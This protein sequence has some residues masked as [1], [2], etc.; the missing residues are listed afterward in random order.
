MPTVKG[1]S[2]RLFLQAAN[3]YSDSIIEKLSAKNNELSFYVSEKLDGTRAFWDGGMTRG[4][5]T[6]DVP[7]ANT[8]DPN[9][10]K[11]KSKI[12][13]KSTGLWSRYGNPIVL[14]EDFLDQLPHIPL[15]GEIWC[16]RGGFEKS[17]RLCGKTT[18]TG[19]E[20]WTDLHYAIYSSPS[21]KAF[22]T[23]GDVDERNFS[24]TFDKTVST[25]IN[26]R[27]RKIDSLP[28]D[29]VLEAEL[30]HIADYDIPY[31]FAADDNPPVFMLAHLLIRADKLIADREELLR[32]VNERGGEGL[33]AR[34][35]APWMPYRSNNL[36]KIKPK[37]DDEA[38]IIGFVS[39]STGVTSKMLG[40]IGGLLVEFNNGK[41]TVQFELGVGLVMAD[42]NFST[43]KATDWARN[44]PDT[45]MP[46]WANGKTFKKGSMVN[47]SYRELTAKGIPK[48]AVYNY[49]RE[50]V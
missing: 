13:S 32:I 49:I 5:D 3:Q 11:T 36:L 17:R 14:P 38:K 18:L 26:R 7:W 35:N 40:L 2:R 31:E 9:T 6:Q 33:I 29:T 37:L 45:Q 41:Q 24:K 48:E 21:M 15:D 50:Y 8:L 30:D 16:G 23:H 46:A 10:G 42:R 25:F 28:T 34:L 12:K 39:G 27:L 44:N 1:R 4:M 43:K 22:A 47:F 19:D 20:D